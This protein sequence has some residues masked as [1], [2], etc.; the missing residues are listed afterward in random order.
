MRDFFKAVTRNL[1]S[2]LGVACATVSGSLILAFLLVDLLGFQGGPYLG[3]LVFAVLP[4]VLIFGLI[5]IPIGS[6]FQRRR[7]RKAKASLAPLT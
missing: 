3:I 1:V 4:A 5:L 2:L 7:R 6:Y